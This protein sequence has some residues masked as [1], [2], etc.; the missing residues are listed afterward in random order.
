MGFTQA[1][2]WRLNSVVVCREVL[3]T[4]E[5]RV[6]GCQTSLSEAMEISRLIDRYDLLLTPNCLDDVTCQH[7]IQEAQA[8]G[9]NPATIYGH[10][11][12][13]SVNDRVRKA[14]RLHLSSTTTELVN[15]RLI[16]HLKTIEQHF[17]I[18]LKDCEEPQFLRYDVGDF[19][20]AHQDGNTGLLQ[21]TSDAERKVSVVIFLNRQSDEPDAGTYSGGSLKFSD[22]R[23]EPQYRELQLTADAGTLVAFRSELTHEVTPVT[24]GKRYTIVSWYR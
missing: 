5:I 19:F 4:V 6:T 8:T 16:D 9:S 7:V 14:S 2:S 22:Y 21:L 11:D 12:V 17:S 3:V 24:H 10:S 13:G 18:S 23:A 15:H 20:V 1:G